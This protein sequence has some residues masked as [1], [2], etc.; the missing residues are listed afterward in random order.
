MMKGLDEDFL[1]PTDDEVEE[2]TE[3][4]EKTRD[5]PSKNIKKVIFS[6]LKFH[7]TN[8]HHKIDWDTKLKTEPS[9][10]QTTISQLREKSGS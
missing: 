10:G 4:I 3:A 1:I 6:K 7:A 9:F 5:M 8:Y 2:D